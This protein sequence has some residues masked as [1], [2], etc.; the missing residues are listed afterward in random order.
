[1]TELGD[2]GSTRELKET[3][4]T[5][6]RPPRDR[7]PQEGRVQCGAGEGAPLEEGVWAEARSQQG[8]GRLRNKKQ[9]SVAGGREDVSGAG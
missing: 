6:R 5:L 1:M 8:L 7:G 4:H 3:G 9:L 2:C